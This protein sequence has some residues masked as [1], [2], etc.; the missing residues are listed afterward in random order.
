MEGHSE[1]GSRMRFEEWLETVPGEMTSDSLWKMKVYRLALF[2]GDLGWHDVTRLAGERRTMALADQMY[3]S[4]GSI[5][6]NLAEGYSRGTGRDRAHFYEYALGSARE[7]RDWYYKARHILKEEVTGHRVALL[8]EIIRL[9][10]AM[11]PQQRGRVLREHEPSYAGEPQDN[12]APSPSSTDLDPLL[13]DA[14]L[15]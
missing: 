10:L 2:A 7:S 13:A 3:R 14:P 4:L 1:A 11:V 6:A 9:L 8:T 12:L 5:S 15:P